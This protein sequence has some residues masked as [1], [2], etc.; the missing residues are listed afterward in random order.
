MIAK[1]VIWK[2]GNGRKVRFWEDPWLFDKPLMDFYEWASHAPSCI[3]SFS[4]LVADYCDGNNW[5]NIDSIHPSLSKL[6]TQLSAIWLNKEEDSLIWK[7]DPKG[8]FT[9]SL[10]YC[11]LAPSP[12]M[13]PFW[14][15]AWLKGL[16]PKINLFFCTILQNKILTI[17][18]LKCRGFALPNRCVLCLQEEESVDH[19]ALHYSFS[20]SIW[21]SFLKSFSLAWV[22]PSN[23]RDLFSSWQIHWTNSFLRCMWQLSLPNILW[24]LWKE[25]NNRIFRDVSLNKDIIFQKIQRAI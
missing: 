4:T 13:N 9:V 12:P 6:K 15:K 20:T 23:I 18:N 17:D 2:L 16:T 24:G 7:H 3:G 14:S 22:F 21:E 8:I 5:Q 10:M 19:L 1:G 11:I 25:R